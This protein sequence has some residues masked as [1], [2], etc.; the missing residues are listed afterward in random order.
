M[1]FQVP[2]GPD[3]W[4]LEILKITA[5]L[6]MCRCRQMTDKSAD[7]SLSLLHQFHVSSSPTLF[8]STHPPFNFDIFRSQITVV[9][10]PEMRALGF[11]QGRGLMGHR[12]DPVSFILVIQ[13]HPSYL[14]G[15]LA[16]RVAPS[17]SRAGCQ[18]FL[19]SVLISLI[20]MVSQVGD[21]NLK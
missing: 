4:W 16:A 21:Q 3:P 15:V 2:Q 10:A 13:P 7:L 19:S 8:A 20:G 1:V 17:Q 5:M 11:D 14:S 6:C 18:G 12:A 9:F